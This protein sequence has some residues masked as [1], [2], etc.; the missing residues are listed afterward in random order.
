MSQSIFRWLSS[1][2]QGIVIGA[3]NVIPGVSGGTMA[4]IF[5][6][7]EQIIG[8][9][10]DLFKAGLLLLKL[11]FR[12][13]SEK[14]SHIPWAFFLWLTGGILIAPLLGAKLIPNA[15]ETWPE[16]SRSLFFGLILGTIPI[17]W[18]RIKDH[19]RRNVLFLLIAAA[20]SFLIVGI[21]P[22][23]LT[24]PGLIAVFFAA[25]LAIC[26][27]ILPGVSGAFILLIL[28]MYVPVFEAIESRDLT[29]IAVFALGAGLGL[30]SFALLLKAL[31]EKA[32]DTTM[33]VLVGLMMGS[34]RSL[35]PWLA[36]DRG[37]LA[38]DTGD[39]FGIVFV[40]GLAGLAVSSVLT[41]IEFRA[42]RSHSNS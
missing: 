21:P 25:A 11:D 33:A 13:F 42:S 14:M 1:F 16:E 3:A 4:L 31:L 2:G 12:G 18:I 15:L 7:Y 8:L 28:G 32:H 24:D 29:V 5:G 34:L 36:E 30:G 35:W 26:A 9:L 37:V 38:P 10:G 6:I 23:E 40:L 19:R 22:A 17:P 41:L 39:G 20:V 27:M